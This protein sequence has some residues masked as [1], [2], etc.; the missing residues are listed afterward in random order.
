MNRK[1]II[2]IIRSKQKMLEKSGVKKI[3]LFGSYSKSAERRGSDVDILIE[4]DS[5]LSLSEL[6]GIKGMI[7]GYLKRKVDL[8]EYGCIHPLIRK[9][10]LDEEVRII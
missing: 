3:G 9:Q 1:N 6:V 2:E 4:V 8:V 7:E 10:V 5:D